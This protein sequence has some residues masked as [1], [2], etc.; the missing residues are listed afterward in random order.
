MLEIVE[1]L[2][3]CFDEKKVRY[4]HWKSNIH[5]QESLNGETDLDILVDRQD[6]SKV[7][8]IFAIL[9]IKRVRSL[10]YQQYPSISDY[11]GYDSSSGEFIHIHLH[12]QLLLG[13]SGIKECHFPI[14][15]FFLNN[16]IK[17]DGI[18][19]PTYEIELI[20]YLIRMSFKRTN[21]YLIKRYIR[22][23]IKEKKEDEFVEEFNYLINKINVE[24]YN[25]IISTLPVK[26]KLK[27]VL[28]KIGNSKNFPSKSQTIK[29][30]SY[31]PVQH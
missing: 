27:K 4:C 7:S 3:K 10:P 14:E 12:Y 2:L 21:Y 20:I 6:A 24:I 28:F 11:I 31:F 9:N 15:D 29:I 13:S 8:S 16:I 17:K 5:L 19:I 1:K 26:D 23:K 22:N 30:V 18:F 25:E